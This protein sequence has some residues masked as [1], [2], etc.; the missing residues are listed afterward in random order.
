[1]GGWGLLGLELAQ[2]NDARAWSVC[3]MRAASP[4]GGERGPDP[5]SSP[6]VGLL[7]PS[8]FTGI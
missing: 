1:M 7:C 6:I 5:S 8:V 2:Q 4:A 3:E